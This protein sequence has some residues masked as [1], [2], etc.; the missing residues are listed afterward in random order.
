MCATGAASHPERIDTPDCREYGHMA[1]PGLPAGHEGRGTRE[2]ESFGAL[3]V[4][5]SDCGRIEIKR[6]GGE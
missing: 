4:S 3:L 2:P 5:A 6:K 1:P